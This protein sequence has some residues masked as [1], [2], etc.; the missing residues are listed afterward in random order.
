MFTKTLD[1]NV[2]KEKLP[3]ARRL[4]VSLF[5][6][7]NARLMNLFPA[8]FHLPTPISFL[9]WPLLLLLMGVASCAP[10]HPHFSR[11][12]YQDPA[13]EVTLVSPLFHTDVSGK[14][15][16]HPLSLTKDEITHLL[17]SIQIKKEMSFLSYYLLR[18][19]AKP[20]PLFPA[21]VS[22][23]LAPRIREALAKAHPEEI[24]AFYVTHPR[25]DGIP[26]VTSGGLAARGDHLFFFLAHADI[27]VT[28]E[29]KRKEIAAQP[30][31]VVREK[32]FQFVPG[33]YQSI[34]PWKDAESSLLSTR[35]PTL[36]IR[37][38]ALLGGS[39]PPAPVSEERTPLQPRVPTPAPTQSLEVGKKLQQIKDWHDQGLISQEEYNRKRKEI[40]QAY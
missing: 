35:L 11:P 32:D 25:E 7:Y 18:Q 40:L 38:H 4:D 14:T 33:T 13:I 31:K 19:D 16:D 5:P 21:E 27:P 39:L 6:F 26:L 28:S 37:Y 9:V 23:L 15:Y 20:V 30:L 10:S 24:V 1:K 36:L 29:R 22:E 12:V 17:Q 2:D 8:C 34:V 3:V